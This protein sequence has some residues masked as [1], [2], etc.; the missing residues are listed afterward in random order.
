MRLPGEE[1]L[2]RENAF[3]LFATF[4]GDIVRT[5]HALNVSEALVLKVCEDEGWHNKLGP[6]LALKK[7]T[8]PG[9]VER[10]V[11]RA[12]NFTQAHRMRLF[13]GRVIHR[14]TGMDDREFEEYLMS[15]ETRKDGAVVKKLSTRALADLASAM[16]KAHALT[17]M[18]LTDTGQDRAKRKEAEGDDEASTTDL[19]AKI[20]AGLAA[21]RNSNTPRAQ[22]FDAQLEHAQQEQAKQLT[23]PRDDEY[24]KDEH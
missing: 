14:V 8:R 10:A 21:V 16:E 9:D 12:L 18:A 19:H 6:I 15:A 7:S 2:D 23:K 22:L 13:V 3:L 1:N 24:D 20:A 4:C 17:Y 11:N 5:A